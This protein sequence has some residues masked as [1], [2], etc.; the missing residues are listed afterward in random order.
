MSDDPHADLQGAAEVMQALDR[1][2]DRGLAKREPRGIN[3]DGMQTLA[4]LLAT[5]TFQTGG[6][7]TQAEQV[8]SATA[9]AMLAALGDLYSEMSGAPTSGV[10]T[11]KL[12]AIAVREARS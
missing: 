10:D 8:C 12:L 1:L 5:L 11:L 6:G 3:D 7:D 9:R 4:D 2:A